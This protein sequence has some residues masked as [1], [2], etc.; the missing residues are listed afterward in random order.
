[1]ARQSQYTVL[2][3]CEGK[4]TEPFFFDA[5]RDRVMQGRYPVGDISITL[6]PEPAESENINQSAHNAT[7][8]KDYVPQRKAR[9]LLPSKQSLP[10][11]I[12]GIP[13]LKWVLAAQEQLRD[14][15]YNEAWVVF[16]KDKH[17]T[18]QQALAKAIEDI[19]GKQVQVA[20]TSIAFEYYLLLH[21]ERYYFPFQ[22]AECRIGKTVLNCSTASAHPNECSGSKCVGGYA[23]QKGYW[24]NSK[25]G[26]SMFPLVEP[27]LEAGFWNAAWVRH[28][29]LLREGST[30]IHERNPYLTTDKII[31][32]LIGWAD[33][34]YEFITLDQ[35]Y[36]IKDS[37]R[38]EFTSGLLVK[39]TNLGN[40]TMIIPSNT[41][42]VTNQNTRVKYTIG[43]K[44]V[45]NPGSE[46][47][48]PFATSADELT[49]FTYSITID[50]I[51]L[52]LK[53]EAKL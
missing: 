2:I 35:P 30:P 18:V 33:H 9:Q 38:I 48:L 1:M 8:Q 23:R 5:I 3:I 14:G 20:Y 51:H 13:P 53:F 16:D 41:I 37:L 10:P 21:F 36:F 31:K 45:I 24:N 34:H 28:E 50:A 19:N 47:G 42:S 25:L 46:V 22:K 4:N 11:E 27:L 7:K 6:H 49:Q 40:V 39:I 15:T 12:P 29:S 44:K 17:P 52:G 26:A 43:E 32:R